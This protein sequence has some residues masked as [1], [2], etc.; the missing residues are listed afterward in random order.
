MNCAPHLENIELI[1]G[2]YAQQAVEDLILY[3]ISFHEKA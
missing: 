2:D 1:F 3:S